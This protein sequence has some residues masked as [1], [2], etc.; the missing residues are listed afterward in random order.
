[1]TSVGGQEGMVRFPWSR[2]LLPGSRMLRQGS[3]TTFHTSVDCYKPSTSAQLQMGRASDALK[4]GP[5][6]SFW[7]LAALER[8]AP[9]GSGAGRHL[10]CAPFTMK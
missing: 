10:S 9:G 4:V 6:G 1:M 3:S 5:P 7:H 2:A 8:A